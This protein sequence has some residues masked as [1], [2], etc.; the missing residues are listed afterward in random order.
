[1]TLEL[2]T[3][4]LKKKRGR[5]DSEMNG[6]IQVLYKYSTIYS[7]L[8]PTILYILMWKLRVLGEEEDI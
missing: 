2:S 3:Y 6:V 7:N 1:M 5:L 8:R 4:N